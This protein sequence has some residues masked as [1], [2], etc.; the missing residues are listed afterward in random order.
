[1]KLYSEEFMFV[2]SKSKCIYSDTLGMSLK[3]IY[4]LSSS[5][6]KSC[7]LNLSALTEDAA[8]GTIK[9]SLT[10]TPSTAEAKCYFWFPKQS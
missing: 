6:F 3:S 9:F 10:G 5:K 4:S 1:M 2:G 8:A 7:G